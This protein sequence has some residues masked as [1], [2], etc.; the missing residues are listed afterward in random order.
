[1]GDTRVGEG[2]GQ[3]C[4]AKWVQGSYCMVIKMWT[5]G[6]HGRLIRARQWHGAVKSLELSHDMVRQIEHLECTGY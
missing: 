1:M 5:G 4:V 2:M 3:H 6:M